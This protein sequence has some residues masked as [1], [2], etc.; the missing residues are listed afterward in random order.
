MRKMVLPLAVFLAS[1]VLTGCVTQPVKKDLSAFTA[2]APCSILIVPVINKSLDVDAPNY[3]LSALPVPV[4]EKGYY[5]FPVNTNK[6]VLE[7]E[8]Y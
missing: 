7:Q 8:G 5:V 4:A 1:I 2:S 3:V 6:Y